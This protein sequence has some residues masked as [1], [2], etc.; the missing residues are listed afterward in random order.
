M[1]S[2]E[3]IVAI[4]ARKPESVPDEELREI[5]ELWNESKLFES[6]IDRRVWHMAFELLWRR[7]E[8]RGTEPCS[9]TCETWEYSSVWCETHDRPWKPS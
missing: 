7:A 9:D 8:M 5:V 3:E 1:K 2:L 4:N 6:W